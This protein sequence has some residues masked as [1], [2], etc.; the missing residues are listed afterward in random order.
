MSTLQA[1]KLLR[2]RAVNYKV[3]KVST[4]EEKIV[5]HFSTSKCFF[6]DGTSALSN[7]DDWEIVVDTS[8]CPGYECVI[9]EKAA[10]VDLLNKFQGENRDLLVSGGITLDHINE[11][12]AD[13]DLVAM[14]RYA[15]LGL[16]NHMKAV[17]DAKT[18]NTTWMKTARKTLY[19]NM[20]Q[21]IIDEFA[22]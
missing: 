2:P 5:N 21:A 8:H 13:A 1:I 20:M 11:M 16:T 15:N 10:C 6:G 18:V 3:K 4:N 14:E 12:I 17:W 22:H 9:N 19:S 7:V